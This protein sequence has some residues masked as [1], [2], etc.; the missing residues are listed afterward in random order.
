MAVEIGIRINAKN[1]TG[2]KFDQLITTLKELGDT[3]YQWV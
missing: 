2:Q 1:L 3:T